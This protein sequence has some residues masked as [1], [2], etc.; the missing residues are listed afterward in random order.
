MTFHQGAFL[1][2]LVCFTSLMA[3][4]CSTEDLLEYYVNVTQTVRDISPL[5]PM[6]VILCD[7]LYSGD[8][9]QV[10][11]AW[12]CQKQVSQAGIRNCI[13]QNTVGCNY[14]SLPEIIAP[15]TKVPNFES[16][17]SRFQIVMA[18]CAW[19]GVV[20]TLTTA[21]AT[22]LESTMENSAPMVSHKPQRISGRCWADDRSTPS[23][24]PIEAR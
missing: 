23:V 2:Y 20:W 3:S 11:H 21:N 17:Y 22:V 24:G 14:L 9:Q 15:D 4:L 5:M 18:R 12:I 16:A 7:C 19:T 10:S 8:H 1:E 13:P 6:P